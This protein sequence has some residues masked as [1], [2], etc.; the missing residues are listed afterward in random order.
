QPA[1]CSCSYAATTRTAVYT[2]SLHDALPISIRRSFPSSSRV[3]ARA[4]EGSSRRRS[5]AKVA[6]R[7]AIA[8]SSRP[9]K[10]KAHPTPSQRESRS[11]EHTSELQS[12]ENLVC[13]LLLEKKKKKQQ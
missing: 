9:T 12:R 11:E 8:R 10:R 5:A 4:R 13:R 2:L 6:R 1:L 7:P 3:S